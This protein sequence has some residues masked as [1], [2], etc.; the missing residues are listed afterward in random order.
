MQSVVGFETHT[1]S[2]QPPPSTQLENKK[3][4][5]SRMSLSG[6]AKCCLS[7]H[8]RSLR[9]FLV[10]LFAEY[11]R[12]YG[13]PT[14]FYMRSRRMSMMNLSAI[15]RRCVR[16]RTQAYLVLA[17]FLLHDSTSFVVLF[18]RSLVAVL[19]CPGNKVGSHLTLNM[20]HCNVPATC[21]DPRMPLDTKVES[22]NIGSWRCFSLPFT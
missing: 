17:E 6:G 9:N 15:H 21:M 18:V 14:V 5:W 11:A 10:M 1:L 19:S 8:E 4:E 2:C 7:S 16:C 12:S 20:S 22:L 3:N 13:D